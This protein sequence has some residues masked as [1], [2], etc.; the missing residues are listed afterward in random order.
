ME[1]VAVLASSLRSA[2]DMLELAADKLATILIS[3][4]SVDVYCRILDAR[5]EVAGVLGMLRYYTKQEEEA[6]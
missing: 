3:D 1:R 4:T 6:A 2:Q 5:L